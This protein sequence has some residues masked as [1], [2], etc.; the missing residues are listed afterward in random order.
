PLRI[1]L[2]GMPDAGKT[3]LLGGLA[4]SAQTQEHLLNGHLADP[5]N[6]LAEL[7]HRVYDESPR[8]TLEEVVPYPVTFE[9]FTASKAAAPTERQGAVLVDCDGR[10]ANELLSRRRSLETDDENTLAGQILEA[11][12]LVLVVDGS[13]GAAQIDA[14]FGEFRKFLRL[15]EE[16]RGRRTE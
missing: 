1:V 16:S 2:F 3:S 5:A 7:Q 15:L 11:D 8:E 10:V 14:D 6:R 9:P 4:Q 13:A 12:A